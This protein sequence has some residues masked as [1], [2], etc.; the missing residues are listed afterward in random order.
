MVG[1][2]GIFVPHK[3]IDIC[4]RAFARLRERHPE[5]AYLFVGNHP[6][7]YDLPGLIHGL[8]LDDHVILTGWMD[9]VSF[10]QHMYLLDIGIHLRYPHIG[11][12]PFSPIRMMGM[13]IPLLISDIGPLAELPEGTCAKVPPDEFEEEI[14]LALLTYLADD[15]NARRQ[16]G[17]NG[18]QWIQEH[19]DARQIAAEHIA[20]IEQAV[21][22]PSVSRPTDRAA[23][24]RVAYLVREMAALACAWG[25]QEQDDDS[26]RPLAEAIWRQASQEQ[27][28]DCK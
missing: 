21:T 25:I 27:S 18:V 3:R 26:L 20:A 13:G 1:S 5:A 28:E 24:H 22:G 9:P 19:H 12:T 16:L 15:E 2:C 4:L 14:V 11:G 23:E 10:T 6:P 7:E 17:K 8:D